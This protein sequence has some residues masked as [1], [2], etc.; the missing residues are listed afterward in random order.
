[1]TVTDTLQIYDDNTK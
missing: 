1:M